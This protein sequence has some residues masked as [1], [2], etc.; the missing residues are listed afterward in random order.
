[1][2]AS[3]DTAVVRRAF[4]RFL[5]HDPDRLHVAAH[6]HHPWPD[7]TYHAHEQAW[8]DAAAR[9]DHKWDHIFGTVLPEFQGHVARRLGLPDPGTIA[10]APNTHE[11]VVR[12]LSCLTVPLDSMPVRVLT[13]DAEFHSF[14]RQA[15][16]LE[17]VGLLDVDRVAAQPFD[18]F[19]ERFETSLDRNGYDLVY[20]SQVHFDS[21]YVVPDLVGLVEAVEDDDTYIVIDGY[22]GYL[23]LPTDLRRIADRAFYT[24]GGY[25]Y[26]MAGEG[27]A[28][29]HCPPD[30]GRRPAFTGWYAG[31]SS[32]A[33]ASGEQVA[34]GID[35]SRFLG[36]TFD[37]S[38]LYRANAVHR[39]LDAVG[40]DAATI[41]A[42]VRDLQ[43]RFVAMAEGRSAREE[44]VAGLLPVDVTTERG[45]FLTFVTDR[46][47][48]LEEALAKRN[49]IVDHRRDR[50]RFGFGIYHQP[51]DLEV[52]WQRLDDVLGT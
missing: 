43:R 14:A 51:R 8:V 7:V 41:H 19:L 21:G 28:F 39:W 42:H 31:F 34:Y 30:Y 47:A 2:S 29:L 18:T 3:F 44:L 52:L 17:E 35:G 11:L 33:D 40:L 16:R 36:A 37:P 45:N 38:G 10:I 4:A 46:A 50:L 49:V 1:M 32:L 25:K 9:H 13:T 27:S 22:H 48:E 12:V 23:A 20:V 6:S 26:A 15:A 24:S 5:D